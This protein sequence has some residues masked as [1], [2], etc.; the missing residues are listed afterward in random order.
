VLYGCNTLT[1]SASLTVP[2]APAAT[3]SE[4]KGPEPGLGIDTDTS[5]NSGIPRGVTDPKKADS[6]PVQAKKAPMHEKAKPTPPH[7]VT[8]T[9]LRN[10]GNTCYQNA[11]FQALRKTKALISLLQSTVDS[12]H[13]ER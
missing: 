13:D 8:R 9:G 5:E 4:Y 2:A 12:L 11:L 6:T 7:I 3:G 10:A 1:S